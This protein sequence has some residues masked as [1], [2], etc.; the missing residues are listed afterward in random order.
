MIII[1][2]LCQTEFGVRCLQQIWAVFKSAQHTMR[3]HTHTHTHTQFGN[4]VKCRSEQL[5]Q[6][7]VLSK[8]D[9]PFN[10]NQAKPGKKMQ[11]ARDP[12]NSAALTD[13]SHCLFDT[14][15]PACRCIFYLPCM[16]THNSLFIWMISNAPLY[17]GHNCPHCCPACMQ[18]C[19]TW[20]NVK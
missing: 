4:S 12:I 10:L 8:F 1:I 9:R 7:S 6:H 5:T 17:C 20:C 3:T 11:G 18:T 13:T 16:L 19:L 14:S 15:R 2:R